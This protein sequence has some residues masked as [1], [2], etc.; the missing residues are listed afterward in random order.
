MHPIREVYIEVLEE[1]WE[2]AG[3]D[4]VA[5]LDMSMYGT[6]DA[7]KNWQECYTEHFEAIGFFVGKANPC[8]FVH[9]SRNRVAGA[10]FLVEERLSEPLLERK[11]F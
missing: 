8:L 1:D 4:R 11:Q 7:A 9:L 3:E 5:K 10:R 2:E 6:R